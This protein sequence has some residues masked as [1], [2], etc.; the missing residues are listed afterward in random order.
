LVCQGWAWDQWGSVEDPVKS[1]V[2]LEELRRIDKR[3]YPR[4]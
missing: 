4:G 1:E 3:A 2:R